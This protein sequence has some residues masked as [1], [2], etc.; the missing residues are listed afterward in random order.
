MLPLGG[1]INIYVTSYLLGLRKNYLGSFLYG[2]FLYGI[3]LFICYKYTN[4]YPF[5]T[6]GLGISVFSLNVVNKMIR[7]GTSG[8]PRVLRSSMGLF[9][10][11]TIPTIINFCLSIFFVY[12]LFDIYGLFGFAHLWIAIAFVTIFIKAKHVF[13][14]IVLNSAYSALVICLSSIWYFFKVL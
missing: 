3:P 1:F 9:F 14:N 7:G 2:L 4:G 12:K 6:I 11:I 5:A 8:L 13:I 10:L